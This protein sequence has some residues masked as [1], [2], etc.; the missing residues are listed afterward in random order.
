[1]DNARQQRK[2]KEP[3]NKDLINQLD[4]LEREYGI[5]RETLLLLLE[6]AMQ[7]A[8]RKAPKYNKNIV[9]SI[10]RVTC[11]IK[12]T[13][14]LYV[15]NTV[16]DPGDEIALD[17]I[18]ELFTNPMFK[19]LSLSIPGEENT[20]NDA[21]DIQSK[22]DK[23]DLGTE[24]EMEF[25]PDFYGRI[26]AQTVWNLFCQRIR[27]TQ[28]KKICAQY[29]ERLN[30]LVTG[31]VRSSDR[32]GVMVGFQLGNASANAT[33]TNPRHL[34]DEAFLP[35]DGKIPGENLEIGNLVTALLIE[36]DPDRQ[37]AAMV[38]SRSKPEFVTKLFEREVSEI[39]DGTVTIKSIAR[40]P[41]F[42]SKLAVTSSEPRVD[43]VGAC[44]GQ[45]GSRV[46]NVVS[47]LNGEKVDIIQ[48]D[49]DQVK[50]ITNAL[51]PAK[52]IHIDLDEASK[53]AI[54]EVPEDQLSL[55]IGKRAQ[56]VKLASIL[57]G[58]EIKVQ[59]S[60]KP[61]EEN[62]C[63]A[64]HRKAIETIGAVEGIGPEAAE[65]LVIHGFNSLEGIA[66]V[67]DEKDIAVLEGFDTARANAVIAAAK[68]ALQQ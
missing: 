2:G 57:T 30:Q 58:W 28:R 36:V 12:C 8:A 20:V 43:P 45:R 19:V 64:D 48:W 62:K 46:R 68:A 25:S 21:L 56:N 10:D 37:G 22:I 35:R 60:E 16:E 31:E 42:R 32:E 40:I 24:I 53:K 47:E 3:K 39:G 44:V 61:A 51:K 27:Q 41:G 67:E 5:D 49:T 17:N 65:I 59:A 34:D 18:K 15:V 66:A 29:Q 23:I 11:N 54:V 4:V 63:E 6:D 38:I 26:F 52:I 33:M 55:T 1:M 50:F 7:F 13:A 9:V 14:K